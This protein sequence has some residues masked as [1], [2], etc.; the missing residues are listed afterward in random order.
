MSR[1]Q[2][3]RIVLGGYVAAVAAA[4]AAAWLYNWHTSRLPYDT[5]GG[6]YAAGEAMTSVA[7]FLVVALIP[8]LI[9]LWYLRGNTQFWNLVGWGSLL[10]AGVSLLSVLIVMAH[11]A[12]TRSLVL[13]LLNV[14]ALAQLL[15]VPFWLVG[16]V[17]F[18]VL[19]PDRGSR[20][21]ILGAIAIELVIGLCAFLHWFVPGSRF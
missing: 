20:R 13:M 16:F 18:A 10:F 12:V 5:S 19:A 1:A 2:K 3:I 8:T 14:L 4:A 6:M 7:V 17:L 11:P 21:L 15:G 9:G